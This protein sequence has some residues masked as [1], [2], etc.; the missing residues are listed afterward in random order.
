MKRQRNF[1]VAVDSAFFW[2]ERE[3]ERQRQTETET[4]TERE[5]ECMRKR[6]NEVEGGRWIII[7]HL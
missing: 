4:E 2:I 5:R 3:R 6:E 1:F 7:I